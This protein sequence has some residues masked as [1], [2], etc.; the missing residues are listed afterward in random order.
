[1]DDRR[2]YQQHIEN[3]HR[4]IKIARIRIMVAFEYYFEEDKV[5]ACIYREGHEV[6]SRGSIILNEH[7]HSGYE[8]GYGNAIQ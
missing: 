6:I 1:M 2:D 7:D 8:N 3:K 4:K 5:A